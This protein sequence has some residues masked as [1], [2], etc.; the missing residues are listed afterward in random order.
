[1]TATSSTGGPER[2]N[3]G[4]A[5]V[6]KVV[7]QAAAF[8]TAISENGAFLYGH[9]PHV[10]PEAWFH[11]VFP[12]LHDD[13]LASLEQRLRR[14]IPP[15]YGQ[16]LKV[17]NGLQLFS[18][19]LS[20]YDLRTDYSR[21]PGIWQP[22]DLGDPNLHERPKAAEAS[23]FVFGFYYEDGSNAYVDPIDGR[24][25]RG[26]RDMR[27]PRLNRW[28]SLD[29]F[30]IAEVRRLQTHFDDRGHQLNPSRPTTPDT[31]LN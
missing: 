2:V 23:W 7:Q 18:H 29:A 12:P 10:A 11:V 16:L 9:V 24:V 26:S 1:M 3:L 13:D 20:L 14:S 6:F 31:E 5:E 25:Y 15:E 27:Q 30:L 8:G 21:K 4:L 17:T 19:N 28:A 22:F